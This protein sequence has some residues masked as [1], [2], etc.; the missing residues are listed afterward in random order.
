MSKKSRHADNSKRP[1]PIQQQRA[2]ARQ[3]G[4]GGPSKQDNAGQQQ[5]RQGKDESSEKKR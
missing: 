1:Q 3:P 5:A 2:Q 4:P